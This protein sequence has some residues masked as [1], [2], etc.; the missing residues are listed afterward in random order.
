[1]IAMNQPFSKVIYDPNQSE[2]A[3]INRND[4]TLY[5]NSKIWK[6]L[7]ANEREF[8]LL[9]EKGHLNLQTADEFQ[10]NEYAVSHFVPVRTLTNQELGKRIVVMKTILNKGQEAA[11][12]GFSLDFVGDIAKVLPV[13]GIGSKSRQEEAAANAAAQQTVAAAKQTVIDAQSKADAKKSSTYIMIGTLMGVIAIVIVTLY[14][15][16]RK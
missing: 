6:G 10:A 2:I 3:K 13:I 15:I 12:S 16:L 7:P 9:H 1:M 8:V 14:F 11:E 5:I 4:G